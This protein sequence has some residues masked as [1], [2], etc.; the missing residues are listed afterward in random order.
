MFNVKTSFLGL[1]AIAF[2]ALVSVHDASAR[3]GHGG[4]SGFGGGASMSGARGGFAGGSAHP[5]RATFHSDSRFAA[6]GTGFNPGARAV[7]PAFRPAVAYV[8]HVPASARRVVS[9][10]RKGL[11]KH[12]HARRFATGFVGAPLIGYGYVAS[13]NSAY[14][15]CRWLKARYEDTG[16]RKWRL[17]Y[18]ACLED[19][20]Y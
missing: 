4:G 18:E 13:Y 2:A 10:D 7:L 1:A 15:R 3:Q 6:T 11:H 9:G 19:D 14:N 5:A 16:L 8:V 20:D 12:V 17:A